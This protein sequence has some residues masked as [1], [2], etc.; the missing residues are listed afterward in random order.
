M[1]AVPP[2]GLVL[3]VV[4][5]GIQYLGLH[6]PFHR[7]GYGRVDP[8]DLFMEKVMPKRDNGPHAAGAKVYEVFPAVRKAA[9]GC[10]PGLV[11][12]EHP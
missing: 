8:V 5:E 1:E 6:S 10:L 3:P 12:G 2:L 4:K 7:G 9:L 11:G